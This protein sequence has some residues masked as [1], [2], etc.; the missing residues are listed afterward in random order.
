MTV[1]RT[2]RPAGSGTV[3]QLPNGTWRA[4]VDAT[5]DPA[6]GRRRRVSATGDSQRDA[7]G[8]AEARRRDVEGDPFAHLGGMPTVAQWA[9]LWL[10]EVIRPRRTPNTLR[11]YSARLR[12]DIIPLLGSLPLDAVR[13]AHLRALERSILDGDPARGIRPRSTATCRTTLM[14]MYALLEAAVDEGFIER[15]PARA[16]DLPAQEPREVPCLTPDQ[17]AFMISL[18]PDP[19]WRLLWRLMF[20]TGMRVGE[21][22]A[23][24]PDEVVERDGATCIEVAWQIKRFY[25]GHHVER[26]MPR[27]YEAVRVGDHVW[28]TR[29]K[30][31]AGRRVIPLPAPLADELHAYM[32]SMRGTPT[33]GGLVFVSSRG[34]ALGREAI[35]LPWRK[36]LERAGLP[37]VKPHSARHTAA[38]MLASLGVSD[39]TRTAIIGHA[40]IR[41]TNR[42]YTHS[43]VAEMLAATREVDRL[44]RGEAP[45]TARSAPTPM[46]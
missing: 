39:A 15:S 13:P 41:T 14:V 33:P 5:P 40:D 1:R 32:D 16:H 3:T 23:I 7:L 4:Y 35:T 44:V 31:R 34:N 9:D 29:P 30:T 28:L 37:Y 20:V 45:A 25:R 42:V 43:S 36:A 24:T 17:A 46:R 18:E 26:G 10:E 19:K 22:V 21:A 12:T 6:T 8:R 2:R 38:S 11:T 27:G